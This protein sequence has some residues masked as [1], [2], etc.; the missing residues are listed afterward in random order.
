MED[1]K[2][3]FDLH[4]LYKTRQ[5]CSER[6]VCIAKIESMAGYSEY[7]AQQHL[8]A[9]CEPVDVT[10]ATVGPSKAVSATSDRSRTHSSL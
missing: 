8:S 9:G 4:R 7:D 2:R 10:E 5:H 6:R 1:L 3:D